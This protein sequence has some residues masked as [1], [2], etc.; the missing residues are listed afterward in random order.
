MT[1]PKELRYEKGFLS[2]QSNS[3]AFKRREKHE[4]GRRE[5]HDTMFWVILIV[6][7][8]VVVVGGRIYGGTSAPDEERNIPV[9]QYI[10]MVRIQSYCLHV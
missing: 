9:Y 7:L 4:S 1:I 10:S 5:K 3:P 8:V 2:F 6:L